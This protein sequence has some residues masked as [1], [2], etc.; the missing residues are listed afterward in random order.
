M[1]RCAREVEARQSWI[2]GAAVLGVAAPWIVLGLLA[3]R[4]EGAAAYG[5]PEGIALIVAGA[6][7]SLVAYRI[8]LRLGRLPEPRRWFG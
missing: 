8:M 7:L 5:S 4:P 3:M 2:R 1:P 6:V